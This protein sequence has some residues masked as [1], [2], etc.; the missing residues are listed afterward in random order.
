MKKYHKNPRILNE[1]QAALLKKTLIE[2]GDLSG[3]V[4]DVNSDEIIGGN[5]RSD[6][7]DIN[8][9][10]IEIVKKYPKPTK[11][12]TIAEGY[13]LWNDERYT[14]RRVKWTPKQ[15]EKANVIANRA[16]G[17]WDFEILSQKFETS[18]LIE[19]GFEE[20][21]FGGGNTPLLNAT[22]NLNDDNHVKIEKEQDVIDIIKQFERVIIQYSGGK[23]SS[24]V[25]HWAAP[26]LKDLKIEHEACFVDTGCEFPDLIPH[27]CSYCEDHKIKLTILHSHRHLYEFY[28]AK[29]RWPDAIFRDCLH[30]FINHPL[31][32]YINKAKVLILRGGKKDQKITRSK[33]MAYQIKKRDDGS[34]VYLLNP[35]YFTSKEEYK[36]ILDGI[37]LWPGYS[38][39]FI[40]TACWCCPFQKPEQWDAL[41]INYPALYDCMQHAADT[42]K[43]KEHKGDSL[44][45]R[46][47]K[48]WKGV[49]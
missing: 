12:G 45:K 46:F 42:W 35:F 25:L 27:I 11:T 22:K 1:K 28:N 4:H 6:I 9:C 24:A 41:K 29:K 19:W 44:Y 7:F 47:N 3:I 49:E 18:D 5:Q 48:Y 16:G 2:L 33:A 30:T 15:C 40:R 10:K 38:K 26:I 23:D 14:Y 32:V 36:K 17:T 31:D 39:G 43:F 37:K 21:E 13:V 8:K 34:I 20:W